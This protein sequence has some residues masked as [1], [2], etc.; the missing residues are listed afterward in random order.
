MSLSASTTNRP[1]I[2]SCETYVGLLLTTSSQCCRTPTPLHFREGSWKSYS[3][4]FFDVKVRTE[5]FSGA[6]GFID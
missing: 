1:D 3:R 4:S 6:S 2:V 5:T